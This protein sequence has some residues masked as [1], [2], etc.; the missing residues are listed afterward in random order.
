[1]DVWG[2]ERNS[3]AYLLFVNFLPGHETLKA[4]LYPSR[5]PGPRQSN[6]KGKKYKR[7]KTYVQTIYERYFHIRQPYQ[8]LVDADFCIDALKWKIPPAEH[9]PLVFGA[10]AVKLM[11]TS[12]VQEELR[13]RGN[14]DE[15]ISGAVFV[16]K[17]FEVRRCKHDCPKTGSECIQELILTDSNPHHYCAA[18]QNPELRRSLR[19]LPGVP[20]VF[21]LK[22]VLVM[23]A[24]TQLTID[25]ARKRETKKS[26]QAAEL[27]KK[28]IAKQ[29][30]AL[31][32][33]PKAA[34]PKKKRR[35][36]KNP[37][38]L[39][40]KVKKPKQQLPG[41]DNVAKKKKRRRRPKKVALSKQGNTA[42][43]PLVQ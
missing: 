12:C 26:V 37:N 8:V 16:S 42:S 18:A 4:L 13:R 2:E 15:A 25:E 17:R 21:I 30:S 43:A 20:I 3:L 33:T 27:D 11:T 39:S 5:H 34:E 23:E 10:S 32:E 36:P 31:M 41:K 14:R 38:P 35:K 22:G 6:M 1:M 40:C 9:M 7:S 19:S 29:C 24:P 28:I